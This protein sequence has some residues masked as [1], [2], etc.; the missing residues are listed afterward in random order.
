MYGAL[1]EV[2]FKSNEMIKDYEVELLL[3][4]TEN[5]VQFFRNCVRFGKTTLMLPCRLIGVLEGC[6]CYLKLT[7]AV[8]GLLFLC[9]KN[10]IPKIDQCKT[11]KLF[12]LTNEIYNKNILIS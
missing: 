6:N 3:D 8:I 2:V 5:T 11:L 10:C 4:L 1:L 7:D 9:F 12:C